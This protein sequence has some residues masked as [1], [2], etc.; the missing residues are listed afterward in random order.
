[1]IN[2]LSHS[3]KLLEIECKRLQ[4]Q[5]TRL[6]ANKGEYVQALKDRTFW[7]NSY[8]EMVNRYVRLEM[9]RDKLLEES[10]RGGRDETHVHVNFVSPG[11]LTPERIAEQLAQS[12]LSSSQGR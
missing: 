12:I 2:N 1:M 3:V 10:E 4:D 8:N 6:L 5:V 11:H 7:E 9:Q